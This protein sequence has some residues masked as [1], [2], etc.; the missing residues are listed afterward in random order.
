MGSARSVSQSFNQSMTASLTDQA[1]TAPPIELDA[2]PAPR[3]RS[4]THQ[5]AAL[6]IC[7]CFHKLCSITR[8]GMEDG[9]HEGNSDIEIA[10]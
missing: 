1:I 7:R 2:S 3:Q 9:K 10:D 4:Q 6:A 5:R 8:G